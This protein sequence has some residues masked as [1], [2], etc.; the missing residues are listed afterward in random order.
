M[1][2]GDG[3]CSPGLDDDLCIFAVANSC[4][5]R[6]SC[7]LGS[8]HKGHGPAVPSRRLG[9]LSP[10]PPLHPRSAPRIILRFAVSQARCPAWVVAPCS[11]A[12]TSSSRYFSETTRPLF[13]SIP[14][15]Q[16]PVLIAQSPGET[17][18]KIQT[19]GS[20]G[21]GNYFSSL[22]LSGHLE[23]LRPGR[24][25][26]PCDGFALTC[27]GI[28]VAQRRKNCG[29]GLSNVFPAPSQDQSRIALFL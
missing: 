28:L 11:L 22:L 9:I 25:S 19:A 20:S 5:A 13:L 29:R 26:G 18:R 3:Y 16:F 10:P 14:V 6:T 7:S 2:A 23:T 21:F 24:Q 12:I 17:C 4:P 27:P 15:F 1:C 8:H